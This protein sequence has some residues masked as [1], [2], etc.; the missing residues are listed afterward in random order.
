MF[1]YFQHPDEERVF[2]FKATGKNERCNH[3][4]HSVVQHGVGIDGLPWEWRWSGDASKSMDC[5]CLPV[6]NYIPHPSPTSLGGEGI[7]EVIGLLGHPVL[8]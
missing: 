7:T 1:Q 4:A 2:I 6:P 5:P 3:I 8:Q